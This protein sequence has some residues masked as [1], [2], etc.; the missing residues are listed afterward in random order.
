[1]CLINGGDKMKKSILVGIIVILLVFGATMLGV[2]SAPKSNEVAAENISLDHTITVSGSGVVNV[3][4]DIAKLNFGISVQKKTASEAMN[5]LSEKASNVIETLTNAGI[6]KEDIK[7]TSINLRPVYQWD[8]DSRKNVLIG[9]EASESFTVNS[10]IKDAGN[11]LSL[12]VNSGANKVFGISF[13]VSDKD[14]LQNEAISQAMQNARKK[15]EA[16]LKNTNYKITG[17]KTISIQSQNYYPIPYR[18]IAGKEI[19]NDT[20]VPI[21]GGSLTIKANVQVIFTFD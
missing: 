3:V 4:P 21:E 9:Y 16:S 12:A 10:S 15:A 8:K 17:I 5:A 18:N 11:L 7:T 2:K 19:E 14:A 6:K 20:N 1:M 13:D